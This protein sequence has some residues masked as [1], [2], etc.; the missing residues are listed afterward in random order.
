MNCRPEACGSR[1]HCTVGDHSSGRC[2][3]IAASKRGALCRSSRELIAVAAGAFVYTLR[4]H[5]R[6]WRGYLVCARPRL[7]IGPCRLLPSVRRRSFVLLTQA[8]TG[9]V[10]EV[11]VGASQGC[12]TSGAEWA[13]VYLLVVRLS[14]AS[15]SGDALLM[16]SEVTWHARNPRIRAVEARRVFSELP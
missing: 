15:S 14:S 13:I 16:P 6:H 12:P 10:V 4:L 5:V 8:P 7:L 11:A 3:P 1:S 2:A 9:D